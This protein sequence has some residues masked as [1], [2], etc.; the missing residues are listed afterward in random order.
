MGVE[1]R[2]VK[3]KRDEDGG[4]EGGGEEGEIGEETEK[5]KASNKRGERLKVTELVKIP[6]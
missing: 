3:G 6:C 4:G 5:K 2:A 1:G